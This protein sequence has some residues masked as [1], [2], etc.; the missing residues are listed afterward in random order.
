MQ[1]ISRAMQVYLDRARK[2]ED[3]L[4]KQGEEFDLGKRH[5]A[6]MMGWDPDNITQEDIDV[7]FVSQQHPVSHSSFLAAYVCNALNLFYIFLSTFST[8]SCF[9]EL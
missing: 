2:H 9:G 4:K 6:N 1:K 5:L 3:F 8:R 7:S